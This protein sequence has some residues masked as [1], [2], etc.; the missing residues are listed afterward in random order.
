MLCA[1]FDDSG[2]HASS[3][4]VAM[5]GLLGTEEQW[6]V[7]ESSWTS[8]LASPLPGKPRLKQFHL[9]PC[10]ARLDE[11][12]DYGWA[13]IDL[14]THNFRKV[15]LD[16]GL[17]TIACA[18]NKVAWDELIVG[19]IA[20]QTGSPEEL[21]FHKCMESMLNTIRLRKP[22][23]SVFVLFDQ[24]VRRQLQD[25]AMFYESQREEHPE[26]SAIKFA[27]VAKI[28]ALQGADMIATETYQYALEWIK[29]RESPVPN[30]HFRDYIKRELSHG[31]IMDREQ[32]KGIVDRVRET[33]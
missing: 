6:D 7:F 29:N 11:F 20:A 25:Y 8:L 5:G 23:E 4:V 17:V 14:I 10:R 18:V 2:T 13:E 27:P 3:A 15:I 31:Q 30:P 16:V 9:S 22:G 24:G 19:E 1:F 32:I 33:L 21:C 12:Q 26:I 28:V